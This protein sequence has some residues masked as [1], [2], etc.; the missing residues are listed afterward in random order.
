MNY[1]FLGRQKTL[2]FGNY[3]DVSLARAREKRAEAREALAD[4]RDPTEVRKDKIREQ[5]A[6]AAETFAVDHFNT[7]RPHTHIV[8]RG[9]DDRGDN[10][11]IAR[12]YISHGLRERASELVT[13]D[14]GNWQMARPTQRA[15][16]DLG[17]K[18]VRRWRRV[19]SG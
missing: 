11:I 8:L 17:A 6:K 15:T 2:S 18:C 9:V 10:L 13:L 3:P 5:R 16:R 12:E 4:G 7:E 14:L 19:G 1:R